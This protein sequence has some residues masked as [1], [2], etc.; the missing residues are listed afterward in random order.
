MLIFLNRF[1]MVIIAF[2]A[3]SSGVAKIMLMEQEVGFFGEFGFTDTGLMV[4]GIAQVLGG[5]FMLI[6]KVRL[7]GTLVVALSFVVSAVVL[8]LAGNFVVFLATM[9]LIVLAAWI[10]KNILSPNTTRIQDTA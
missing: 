7:L 1:V 10:M 5:L 2:L 8:L 6:G 3:S 4:F 9:A